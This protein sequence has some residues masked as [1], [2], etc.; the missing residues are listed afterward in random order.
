MQH[1]DP[2]LAQR[3]DLVFGKVKVLS[4]LVKDLPHS[5]HPVVVRSTHQACGSSSCAIP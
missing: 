5:Q 3:E 4:L 1:E 2:V